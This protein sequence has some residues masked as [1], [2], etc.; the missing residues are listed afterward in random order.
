L[1][2]VLGARGRGADAASSATSE[3]TAEAAAP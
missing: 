1:R 3:A 2:G